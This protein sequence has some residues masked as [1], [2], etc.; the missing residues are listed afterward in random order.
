M[1]NLLPSTF[2]F[3]GRNKCQ[4]GNQVS[5]RKAREKTQC[6]IFTALTQNTGLQK[7]ATGALKHFHWGGKTWA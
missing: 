7:L 5:V 2:P 4:P 6:S 1:S 3:Q